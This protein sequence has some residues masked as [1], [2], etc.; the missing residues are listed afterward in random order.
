MLLFSDTLRTGQIFMMWFDNSQRPVAEKITEA[1]RFYKTKYKEDVTYVAVHPSANPP[2]EV[3][4][5][6]VITKQN[7]RPHNIHVG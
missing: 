2:A 6:K 5:I 7:V 3:E 1:I 4:G